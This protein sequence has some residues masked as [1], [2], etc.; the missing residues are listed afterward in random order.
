MTAEAGSDWDRT[1]RALQ[2]LALNGTGLGGAVIRMRAG[3]ARDT[4]LAALR[5]RFPKATKLHP[6]IDD[7][8]LFGGV[9]IAATLAQGHVVQ[10]RGL[11]DRAQTL[12]LTMA[13][14]CPDDLSA[15]LAQHLD[16]APDMTLFALDEGA[17]EAET[18]PSGLAERLAFHLAPEGA[19]PQGWV[20]PEAQAAIT[21]VTHT[22]GDIDALVLAAE[23]FGITSLRAPLFALA[24]AR[25]NAALDGRGSVTEDDLSLAAALIYAHRATRVPPDP[26]EAQPDDPP[27]EQPDSE[28]RAE[29]EG[30]DETQSLPQGE[31]LVSAV[32][33]LLPPELLAGLGHKGQTRGTHGAGAGQK[34]KGNR[35]G[36][37]LPSRWGKL[38]GRA[39]LDVVATLRAAA[40]WQPI[41]R[42][43]T[44][45]RDGL[46]IRSSDLRLK[47]YESKSDRL[48][49]FAV[50]A[51]G[52][53]AIS[54]LNEAKGAI[55]LLLGQAYAARDHVALVSFRGEGAECLLAPT[56]SLVQTKRKLAA[57][58]GGG[59]TPLA[60]G[61][62]E[63]LHIAG[64]ARD[65]GLS[66]VIV[67]ATDGKANIALD[68][69]ADRVQAREDATK[70]AAH[71]RRAGYETLVVDMSYRPQ[72]GLRDLAQH[73]DGHY[74]PLPRANA[75]RLSGAVQ[76]VLDGA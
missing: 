29:P 61:M 30:E 68:G 40:P 2:I 35:R 42:K 66:P 58:P 20:L 39:R 46:L 72:P 37:P 60:A 15:K 53:A 71:L 23:Q 75:E 59:G 73:L 51:S 26:A 18:V 11:L 14:R 19:P 8:Q 5:A 62:Q 10:S 47:R 50:D 25:A 3:P 45:D 9:D 38:D 54:R 28:D 56:R 65:R 49:V 31:M 21:E 41:R 76:N 55:E 1:A 57:L 70:M 33:A 16:A 32:K 69:A 67:L 44:P 63:A 6:T 12:I 27:P 13:E 4:V 34:R 74:L 17:D 24:T 64:Q 48:I 36:R 43:L 7:T 52:S 22:D